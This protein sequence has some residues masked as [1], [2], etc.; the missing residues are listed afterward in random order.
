MGRKSTLNEAALFRAVA[1]GFAE[2]G[3][4]TYSAIRAAT[5]V[6]TGSLYHRFPSREALLAECWAY[7][8]GLFGRDF[9]RALASDEKRA[10]IEA[11][12]ATPRFCRNEPALATM[13]FA[14]RRADCVREGSSPETLAAIDAVDAAI[15]AAIADYA[16]RSGRSVIAC[17]LAL[18]AYPKGAVGMFLPTPGVPVSLNSQ[19]R[20]MVSAVLGEGEAVSP[21]RKSRPLPRPSLRLAA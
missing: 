15:E 3:Q 20:Q 12:M 6:S 8:I 2:D 10:G 1:K 14:F 11:A 13:L 21:G 17:R 5:G 19:I 4:F 18:I 16:E 7:A 9:L